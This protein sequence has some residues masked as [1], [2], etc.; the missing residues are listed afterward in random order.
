MFPSILTHGRAPAAT[1]I[2]AMALST[3]FVISGASTLYAQ[4][5]NRETSTHVINEVDGLVAMSLTRPTASRIATVQ[6][7]TALQGLEASNDGTP[8][9]KALVGSWLETVTFPPESGRPPLKSLVSFHGDETMVASDQG[10]VTTDPPF[11]QSSGH[12]AWTQL[13][14]RTFAY[15]VLYLFSDLSGNL[16]AYLKVRGVYTVSQSGN[17]Y[18]GTSFAEVLDT[19]GNVLFSIE[20]TNAGKRIQVELP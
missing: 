1:V 12:G 18:N 15:S 14:K 20:V 11:V 6:G 19:D 8:K 13:N 4:S 3:S 9:K 5:A 7:A 10:G 2:A 17:E 16:Q